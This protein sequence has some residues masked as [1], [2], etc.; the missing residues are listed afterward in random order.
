MKKFLHSRWVF[1]LFALAVLIFPSMYVFGGAGTTFNLP[2]PGTASTV[3]SF[4]CQ[5]TDICPATVLI[6]NLG[7]EKATLANPLVT[8]ADPCTSSAKAILSID[9]SATTFTQIIAANSTNKI[10]VCSLALIS[11]LANTL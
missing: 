9:S 10:N 5:T 1:G 7:V 3:W 6:D 4:V 11:A 2:Q 8:S